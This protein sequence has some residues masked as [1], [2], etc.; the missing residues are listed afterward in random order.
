MSTSDVRNIESLEL[1]RSGILNLGDNWEKTLQEI[2]LAVHRADQYYSDTVPRYWR[3]QVEL[4][5]REMTQALDQLQQKQSAA[6]AS[7]RVSALEAQ[8]RVATAKARLKL[9]RE[10]QA[11]AKRLKIEIGRLCDQMLGPLADMTEHSDNLLPAAASDLG[12]LLARLHEYTD[13]SQ[14]SSL[15]DAPLPDTSSSDTNS[16]DV[17]PRDNDL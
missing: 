1:L 6:R 5:E 13:A 9:C 12:H 10:K 8:K 7:D 11:T 14:L 15:P 16:P 17:K 4:A 3:R 2:R